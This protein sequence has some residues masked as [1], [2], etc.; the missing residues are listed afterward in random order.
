MVS[1]IEKTI[2]RSRK[3]T[4]K[5]YQNTKGMFR[6]VLWGSTNLFKFTF[7]KR[8]KSAGDLIQTYKL[9]HN[10]VDSA[11]NI[12][13]SNTNYTSR[14]AEHKIFKQRFKTNLRKNCYSNRITNPWNALTSNVKNAPSINSFKNLLDSNK[15]FENLFRDFDNHWRCFYYRKILPCVPTWSINK[16]NEKMGL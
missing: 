6:Y 11:W 16:K 5:S 3:G 9:L 13:F 1:T 12:F 4:K 10:H 7:F 2:N 8:Q 15:T 14:N